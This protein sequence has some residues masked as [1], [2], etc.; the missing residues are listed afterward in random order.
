[1]FL[2]KKCGVITNYQENLCAWDS[3]H[4]REASATSWYPA[5]AECRKYRGCDLQRV[6]TQ[7]Q[8]LHFYTNKYM[9][10]YTE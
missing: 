8:L 5:P 1:M 2:E 6:T 7:Q 4:F 9:H 3:E 10:A